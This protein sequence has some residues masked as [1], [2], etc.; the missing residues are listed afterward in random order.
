ME[1]AIITGTSSGIGEATAYFLA[2]EGY[3]VVLAARSLDK[4]ETLKSDLSSKGFKVLA[5]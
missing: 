2:S 3:A 1:T 5:V 4:L